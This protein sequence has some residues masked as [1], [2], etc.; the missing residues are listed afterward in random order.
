VP[1]RRVRQCQGSAW[2]SS[3][4]DSLQAHPELAKTYRELASAAVAA[5][6]RKGES[7]SG[8]QGEEATGAE[9]GQPGGGA[10]KE[11]DKVTAEEPSKDKGRGGGGRAAPDL[12]WTVLVPRQYA[13]TTSRQVRGRN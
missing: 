7:E 5:A 10:P 3:T 2:S 13:T 1:A 12:W 11:K 8:T 6:Q 9:E 4:G